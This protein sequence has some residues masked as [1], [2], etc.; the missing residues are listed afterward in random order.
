[1][2][3]F[4]ALSRSL[5]ESN[6]RKKRPQ[7]LRP[8]ESVDVSSIWRLGEI[9]GREDDE[10][11]AY[12]QK[13]TLYY[14]HRSHSPHQLVST[15]GIQSRYTVKKKT[16]ITL[17]E[18]KPSYLYNYIIFIDSQN[19][20]R[21][22]HALALTVIDDSVW[23]LRSTEARTLFSLYEPVKARSLWRRHSKSA[24]VRRICSNS[25]F[26]AA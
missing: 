20:Q 17:K 10:D 13:R 22:Y 21:V 18:S 19:F 4:Q 1:M 11:D 14:T 26:P 5:V 16:D 7:I 8:R 2:N 12:R 24:V 15:R 3:D 25:P 9:L 23:S 6:N